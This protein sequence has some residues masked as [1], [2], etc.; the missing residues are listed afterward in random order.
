MGLL[1]LMSWTTFTIYNYFFDTTVPEVSL[2]GIESNGYY[3][4]D[5]SCIL[6][7]HD[8]YKVAYITILL[9]GKPLINRYH[10]NKRSCEYPFILPTKTIPN[11]KHT[12]KIIIEDGAYNHNVTEKELTINVDNN[13]LQA[14]FVRPEI[15]LKVFQGRTLHIQ[16]QVNKEIKEAYIKTLSQTYACY[17]ESPN[18]LVYDCY[19]PIKTDETPNEYMLALEI[20]DHVGNTLSLENKFQIIMFPF[21][22]TKL[23]LNPEKIKKEN[24]IGLPERALEQELEELTKK[25]PAQKLWQGSFYAPCD[26]KGISTDFGTVRITQERGKYPHNAV[27]LVGTPKSVIWA[28]Q[29]GIVVLKNRYAH[30]GNTIVIDHGCGL[31]SLFFH[32]DNFAAINVGDRIK[33][34]NPIGT[35]GMT[36]YASGYHLHWGMR[37]NNIDIDPL[38][39]TKHDF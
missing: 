24:E 34:G 30:A 35:L 20:A 13:P 26:M 36:G 2:R 10:I 4:G 1:A 15:D 37:L 23:I 12:I 33:K 19:I 28:T 16:F 17:S 5:V 3:G 31:L 6:L 22:K 7:A 25:S 21:K 11:G 38:Q 29:D 14:T 32:L 9:D 18:S 27:D 39:W 8:G